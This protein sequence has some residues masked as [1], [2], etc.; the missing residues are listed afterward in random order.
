VRIS[1]CRI[2]QSDR[3]FIGIARRV[4]LAIAVLSCFIAT[5]STLPVR[6]QVETTDQVRISELERR[7]NIT[8]QYG[9][10]LSVL[11]TQAAEMRDQLADIKTWTRGIGMAILVAVLEKLM[12]VFGIRI[13]RRP[14]GEG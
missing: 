10:R 8:D 3:S 12:S 13:R 2:C 6:A 4:L 11:E 9:S 7:A 5:L 14:D 1:I